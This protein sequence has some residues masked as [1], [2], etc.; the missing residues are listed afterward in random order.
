MVEGLTMRPKVTALA[1][2]IP[3]TMLGP[4]FPRIASAYFENIRKVTDGTAYTLDEGEF[5]VGLFGPIRYGLLDQVTLVTHPVLH[6]FLTPNGAIE[7]KVYDGP[8]ALSLTLGYIQTFLDREKARFPGTLSFY[9]MLT[10]PLGNFFAITIEGGYI[11]DFSPVRHGSLFGGSLC[12][13]FS[14]ADLATLHVQGEVFRE[15]ARRPTVVLSYTRAFYRLRLSGGVAVGRFPIQVGA[16]ETDVKDLPV[17]PVVDIW[18]Q[19]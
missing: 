12:L 2:F 5:S 8:V 13:L 3:F 11:L 19:W 10:L 18:W 15:G 14:H 9:P 6:L 16:G 1:W 4:S 17:Y 7:G